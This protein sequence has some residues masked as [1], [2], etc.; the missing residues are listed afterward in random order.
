MTSLIFITG[1]S[2]ISHYS[3]FFL[4]QTEEQGLQGHQKTQSTQ[5]G[6]S[7]EWGVSN[8]LQRLNVPSME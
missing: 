7:K 8:M 4:N 3:A 5:S 1:M 2:G 6:Q